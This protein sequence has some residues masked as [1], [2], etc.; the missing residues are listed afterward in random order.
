MTD[1]ATGLRPYY[2]QGRL[3]GQRGEPKD[4]CRYR[5]ADRRCA[6]MRGWYAGDDERLRL[7]AFRAAR[8][9][10]VRGTAFGGTGA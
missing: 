9:L 7:E 8:R 1:L 5:R 10:P 3:A 6:W 4:A 2:D